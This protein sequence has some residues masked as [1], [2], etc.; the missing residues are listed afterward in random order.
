MKSLGIGPTD[1]PHYV[2]VKS[3]LALEFGGFQRG[4]KCMTSSDTSSGCQVVATL[5]CDA[6][7][8]A[9]GQ[10]SQAMQSQ[11]QVQHRLHSH[12]A[13]NKKLKKSCG[14]LFFLLFLHEMHSHVQSLFHREIKAGPARPVVKSPKR[15]LLLPA[16]TRAKRL[17]NIN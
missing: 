8:I 7:L 3:E 4:G 13:F 5:F 15:L 17:Q 6:L 9:L 11:S 16:E 12:E 14:S 2:R 1:A 10:A